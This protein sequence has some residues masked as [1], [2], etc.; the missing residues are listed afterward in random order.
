M[1]EKNA[2]DVEA[3]AMEEH[4]ECISGCGEIHFSWGENP[5]MTH[6]NAFECGSPC[7]EASHAWPLLLMMDL[8]CPA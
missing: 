6:K 2:C 3:V 5:T 8:R 1:T 4:L 7:W